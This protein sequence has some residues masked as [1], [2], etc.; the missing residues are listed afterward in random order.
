MTTIPL[1]PKAVA[2]TSIPLEWRQSASQALVDLADSMM[3]GALSLMCKSG[4]VL[5]PNPKVHRRVIGDL[6]K[7]E[8]NGMPCSDQM[9]RIE[10]LLTGT[11]AE[12]C[13]SDK[14]KKRKKREA[15][16]REQKEIWQRIIDSDNPKDEH[17]RAFPIR[18]P[19]VHQDG[20]VISGPWDT[21]G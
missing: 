21:A 19:K 10:A 13:L 2:N 17:R 12:Q 11:P 20:N 15:S 9:V 1:P 8:T 18:R 5:D 7:Y 3:R 6:R 16:Q 4:R 14:Q